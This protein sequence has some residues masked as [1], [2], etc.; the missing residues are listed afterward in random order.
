MSDAASLALAARLVTV[1]TRAST[2]PPLAPNGRYDI[3]C[4]IRALG[5]Y[6]VQLIN[7]AEDHPDDRDAARA[8][9]MAVRTATDHLRAVSQAAPATPPEPGA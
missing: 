2:L 9:S 5:R 4:A 3:L 7:H 6:E 1:A 8:L